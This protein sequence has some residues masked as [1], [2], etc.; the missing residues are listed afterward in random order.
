MKPWDPFLRTHPATDVT[1]TETIRRPNGV[2][3]LEGFVLPHKDQ[4]GA[5]YDD[6]GGVDGWTAQQGFYVYRN[7]RMLVAGGWLGL[8]SPR[9]WTMEEPYKLA[10]LRLEF[11]NSADHEWDI[12]VKK[13]VA[14]PPRWLPQG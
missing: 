14:R 10:R 2:I 12:D 6:G 8:G 7:R 5:A 13:S 9:S 1:P 11:A 3:E 4:L